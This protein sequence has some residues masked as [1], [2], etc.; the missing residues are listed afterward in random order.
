MSRFGKRIVL[1]HGDIAGSDGTEGVARD[2]D[3]FLTVTLAGS[4]SGFSYATAVIETLTGGVADTVGEITWAYSAQQDFKRS[5]S[6]SV[7]IKKGEIIRVKWE[8]KRNAGKIKAKV[9]WVPY[10]Q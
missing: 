1:F 9:Q 8:D 4:D 10:L 7:P 5:E 3:G 6:V 2:T